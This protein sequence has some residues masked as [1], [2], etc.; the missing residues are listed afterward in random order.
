MWKLQAGQKTLRIGGVD[1]GG[2]PGEHATVLIGTIFYHGQ[3]I[4][5]NEHSGTFDRQKAEQIIVE[6][7]QFSEKTGNPCMVDIVG[8]NPDAVRN[9][10]S[11]VADVTDAPLLLDSPSAEARL[12]GLRYAREVG[13]MERTVYNS[14]APEATPSELA[15]IAGSGIKNAVLLACNFKDFT[16]EGRVKTA[17]ALLSTANQCGI[18]NPLVDMCVIDVPTLGIASK[19]IFEIK[20][21]LGV[22]VGAGTHNAIGTWRGLRSKMGRQAIMPCTAA[23]A[24]LAIAAG[25]DFVLYGPI[26]DARYVFPAAAMVNAAYGQLLIA[27]KS[28]VSKSHPLFKIG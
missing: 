23:A 21:E 27:G 14:L 7:D 13:L 20:N 5:T 15:E 11:F 10:L 24:V 28:K 9:E 8:V 18:I 12:A 2:T 1:L 3:S 6:Q 19:A 22:P 4:L 26:E 25:A 17:R 16:P